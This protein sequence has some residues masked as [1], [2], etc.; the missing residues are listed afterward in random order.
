MLLE[1]I[2]SAFTYDDHHM[3]IKLFL[4]YRPLDVT[5]HIIKNCCNECTADC[6]N[7]VIELSAI[8]LDVIMLYVIVM[9]VIMLNVVMLDVIVLEVIL[10]DVIMLDVIVLGVILQDV[11]YAGCHYAECR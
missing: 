11:I 4:K 7:I 6:R 10:P 3:M 9:D 1:N 2:H 8:M 5:F